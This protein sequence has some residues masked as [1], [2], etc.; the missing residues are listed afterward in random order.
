MGPKQELM[1]EGEAGAGEEVRVCQEHCVC[2]CLELGVTGVWDG[3]GCLIQ[4]LGKFQ[5][6]VIWWSWSLTEGQKGKAQVTQ[7]CADALAHHMSLIHISSQYNRPFFQLL[8]FFP[9]STLP[10]GISA[11]P[12]GSSLLLLGP[13]SV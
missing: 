6:S 3:G 5:F 7:Q 1:G 4:Y 10:L 2:R 9:T 13:Q 11:D 12:S 8:S